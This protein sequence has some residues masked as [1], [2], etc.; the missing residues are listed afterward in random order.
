MIFRLR[1]KLLQYIYIYIWIFAF[2][3]IFAI[4]SASATS[5]PGTAVSSTTI[6]TMT[7]E[8]AN[9]TANLSPLSVGGTFAAS[10]N[11]ELAQF[12]VT[13]NNYSGYTLTI[14]ASDN[15]GKL[16]NTSAIPDAT[17]DSIASITEEATFRNS[18]TLNG[19]WGYQPSCYVTNVNDV[20]TVIDN[21]T[22]SNFLP[23]PTTTATTLDIT[24]SANPSLA[25]NY[26]IGLGA[27][28]EYASPPGAYTN[29]F[30]LAVVANPTPYIIN[31]LDNTNDSSVANL[32]ASDSGTNTPSSDNSTSVA[33]SSAVPTRAGF[34]FKSWCLGT[35]NDST[36]VTSNGTICNGTE[37]NASTISNPTYIGIDETSGSNTINFYALWT[38][39]TYDVTVNFAGAGI[40]SVVFAPANSGD[41]GYPTRT[42]TST[43]TTANL[44][45]GVPYT[46]T[47]NFLNSFQY[48]FV[49]FAI[50]NNANGVIGS[51]STN[52]TTFTPNQ[53]S[54]SAIITATSRV[55]SYCDSNDPNCMQYSDTQGTCGNTLIDARDGKTYT[56]TPIGSLCWMTRNLD[57]SGSTR[58]YSNTSNVP[59]GYPDTSNTAYYA[60]PASSTSGFSNDDT[61]YVYNSNSTTCT[62]DSPCYSY[63][64]HVAAT[65]GTNPSSGIATSDICPKGWRLPTLAEYDALRSTYTTGVSLTG[66][67]FLASYAGYFTYTGFPNGGTVGAYWAADISNASISYRISYDNNGAYTGV[68]SN[69]LGFSVRCVRAANV[70]MQEIGNLDID[71]RTALLNSMTTNVSYTVTDS[72]DHKNYT[73]TKIGGLVWMTKNLDLTG[74][75]TLSPADSNVAAGCNLGGTNNCTLPTSS[76]TGF[77]N[78]AKAYVYNSNSTTCSTSQPCYS[79]YSYAAVSA[80]MNPTSGST[81]SD[82]CPKGW[83][84]PT[85]AEYAALESTYTTGALMTGA[86]FSAVYGGYYGSSTFGYGDVYGFYWSATATDETYASDMRFNS[87]VSDMG[88]HVKQLGFSARCLLDTRT[89]Y[90]KLQAGVLTM[91]D[92]G[93][94]TAS[95]KT[96][97]LS[98]MSSTT[99]YNIGDS[100]DYNQY[101]VAKINNQI[102][103]TKSL[104]LAGNTTITSLD[105][106]VTARYTLPA[107]STSGFSLGLGYVYNSNSLTCSDTSPCYSYY[108]YPAATAGTNPSSGIAASD[109]CPKGW[110]LPTQAESSSLVSTYNTGAKLTASPFLGVYAGAYVGSKYLYGGTI[111]YHWTSSVVDSDNYRSYG[112]YY[113]SSVS[114]VDQFGKNCGFGIRCVAK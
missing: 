92:L 94:L 39:N 61:A 34:T 25:K 19:K 104:N 96:T 95:E 78:K 72:R 12:G 97:L 73:I 105:S 107:S 62:A 98:Q 27:R 9:A 106:N 7:S 8:Y 64:S 84:L 23:S 14:M 101:T 100:R 18:S 22:A 38:I 88:G 3:L 89:P 41:S 28:I 6:L 31:Y 48:E 58:L 1:Q 49:S 40:F 10:S 65:A 85:H 114:K 21:T 29:T 57:L 26:T 108:S 47:I 111:G 102:W 33:I 93:N 36:A 87:T 70:T 109:I 16:T 91:Q 67:P 54:S 81:A 20:P 80:G 51:A 30:T 82:I 45:Y 71:K 43:G 83:R 66:P 17:L 68:T 103:M 112:I 56:T 79:Y 2:F 59:S 5:S 11:T 52:P 113:D 46:M 32:P 76:T 110:R 53:N 90:E 37:Y 75:T 4:P 42:I 69:H 15:E 63:Y 55:I 50:N 24:N 99:S 44:A 35:N 74:G 13:T 86:P 77:T 60:L